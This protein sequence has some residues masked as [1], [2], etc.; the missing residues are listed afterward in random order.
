MNVQ[1]RYGRANPNQT[2]AGINTTMDA[3]DAPAPL[4][5]SFYGLGVDDMSPGSA[6]AAVFALVTAH[7]ATISSAN[8]PPPA[9][10]GKTAELSQIAANLACE[11]DTAWAR[12]QYI[13]SN[14]EEVCAHCGTATSILLRPTDG[15]VDPSGSEF[16]TREKHSGACLRALISEKYALAA[17]E[18]WEQDGMFYCQLAH[19]RGRY[20]HDVYVRHTWTHRTKIFCSFK[21]SEDLCNACDFDQEKEWL[22]HAEEKHGWLLHGD[23]HGEKAER[24]V[25]L[26]GCGRWAVGSGMLKGHESCG[27]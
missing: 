21:G 22:E 3:T 2:F 9:L 23:G 10:P 15:Y 11:A 24:C 12:P 20:V 13:I 19:C 1:Q 18:L 6:A 27:Q 14:N 8:A 7:Q 17:D 5:G 16:P 25:K 4:D 26:C